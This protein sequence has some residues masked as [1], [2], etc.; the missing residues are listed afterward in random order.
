[1][2]FIVQDLKTD[3]P[4][5]SGGLPS[6]YRL[7][8]LAFYAAIILGILLNFLF[9]N[10][11]RAY[12][13][14]EKSWQNEIAE[15]QSDQEAILSKQNQVN[16]ET[17]ASERIADWVEGSRP[18]QPI[19]A[20]IT[21]SMS[22]NATIAELDMQRNPQMPAHLFMT[23]KINNAGSE[24]L[25]STLDALG[26]IDYQTYSAQQVKA[27]NAFDFQATLIWNKGK[28]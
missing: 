5:I 23:L 28:P 25:E 17:R 7:I 18:V 13:R 22:A 8:P 21:R 14:A 19:S 11:F 9:F 12:Q 10:S 3:R 1:M 6:V 26:A 16:E 2:D 15:S 4:N 20:T 24:Q 27:D